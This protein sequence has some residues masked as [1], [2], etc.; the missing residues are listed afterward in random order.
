MGCRTLLLL[1]LRFQW[2]G[3]KQS[4]E[5]SAILSLDF[6]Y[7]LTVKWLFSDVLP[8]LTRYSICT[9][10]AVADESFQRALYNVSRFPFILSCFSLCPHLQ[11]GLL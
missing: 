10:S 3:S 6:D 9:S 7:V 8:F 2:R 1:A 5:K 4:A 11:L